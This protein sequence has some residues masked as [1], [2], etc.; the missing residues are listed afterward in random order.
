MC[1]YNCALMAV[2]I[3]NVVLWRVV[4]KVSL[5]HTDRLTDFNHTDCVIWHLML[6]KYG[7]ENIKHV[8][9][10]S[11]FMELLI[12]LNHVMQCNYS[13]HVYPIMNHVETFKDDWFFHPLMLKPMPMRIM[14]WVESVWSWISF[15][16][17]YLLAGRFVTLLVLL[18]FNMECYCEWLAFLKYF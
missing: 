17:C 4:C 13:L 12:D 16:K 14:C 8:T 2:C 1:K 9:V 18:G 10:C 5:V 7:A 3:K 6:S 11:C 15:D